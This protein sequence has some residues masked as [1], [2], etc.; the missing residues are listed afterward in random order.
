MYIGEETGAE[1]NSCLRSLRELSVESCYELRCLPKGLLRPTL[2]RLQICWCS[3]LTEANPDELRNLMSLQEL[4]LRRCNSRWERCW[5][6]AQFCL[7]CFSTLIIGPFSE[8]L[9][10]FPWP[11]VEMVKTQDPQH[12]PFMFLESLSLEGW[13]KLKFL[14]DQLRHL[15]S[16]RKL[17]ISDFNGLEALPE[18]LGNFSSLESLTLRLCMN[19]T[20]LPSL[21]TFRL[22]KNLQ[23]LA[24]FRC[25]LLKKRCEEERGEELSKIAHIP[26]LEIRE[27]LGCNML[28]MWNSRHHLGSQKSHSKKFTKFFFSPEFCADLVEIF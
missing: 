12:Y 11:E 10:Y 2:L 7:T 28:D 13:P 27:C 25:P 3:N 18:W 9:D 4:K 5:E 22:L 1:F 8:E 23:S 19:L 20:R 26:S 6:E 21:E 15:T 14:P 24:I 17:E 16:L